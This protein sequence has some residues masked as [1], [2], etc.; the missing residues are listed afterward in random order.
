MKIW[1]VQLRPVAG[2]EIE[3]EGDSKIE[4]KGSEMEIAVW[5]RRKQRIG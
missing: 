1:E 2:A 3:S 4:G 5:V